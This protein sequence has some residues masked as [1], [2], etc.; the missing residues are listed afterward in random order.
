VRHVLALSFLSWAMLVSVAHGQTAS[1]PSHDVLT[2]SPAP[3]VLSVTQVSK[4]GAVNAALAADPT[5]SKNLLVGINDESCNSFGFYLSADGG[6]TWEPSICMGIINTQKREYY[7]FNQP[8][9]VYDLNGNAYIAGDYLDSEG[10]GY[11]L[12]VVQKSTNGVNWSQPRLALS[13]GYEQLAYSW[14]S[15]DTNPQSPRANSLYVSSIAI[16]EP[17]QDK[18]Q[19]FVA[20]S[21][22][23]G[24]HWFPAAVDPSQRYP[25]VDIWTNVSTSKDGTVYVTWQHCGA[26]GPSAG[27]RDGTAFML[28]SKSTD[29]GNT[30]S[31]PIVMAKITL[32]PTPCHCQIGVLPNT[33]NI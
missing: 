32:S 19:V 4:Q 9:A 23:G 30:W 11:G 18:N 7:P 26:G 5:N 20:H 27:C 28:F 2:C 17:K 6:S 15:V 22:D 10:L 12:V 8:M 3:C 24:N 1:V 16:N 13:R 29:G 21:N 14:L 25:A 31:A 33:N